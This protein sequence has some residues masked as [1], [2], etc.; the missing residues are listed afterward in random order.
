MQITKKI[1]ITRNVSMLAILDFD[2]TQSLSKI[3]KI[4]FFI[5]IKCYSTCSE[6]GIRNI[7]H[8]FFNQ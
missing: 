2:I 7:K 5:K 8:S 3:N 6:S 1:A 4:V